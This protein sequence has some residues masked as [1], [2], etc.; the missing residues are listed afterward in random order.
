[1]VA[2]SGSWEPRAHTSNLKQRAKRADS[3]WCWF[4][5][6]QGLPLVTSF[7]RKATPAKTPQT[8]LTWITKY[9]NAREYGGHEWVKPSQHV[10]MYV[11]LHAHTHSRD[12][13]RA[14]AGVI[15]ILA[16]NKNLILN[17]FLPLRINS[18]ASGPHYTGLWQ[19]LEYTLYK[20]T[21]W[22][23]LY[24]PNPA[25]RAQLTSELPRWSDFYSH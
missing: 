5:N 11:C 17:P 10:Y 3:K 19:W 7:P 4:L 23:L 20:G 12:K 8:T 13:G 1:M 25:Y 2:E 9:S 22:Q 24:C 6:S 16:S 21:G 18:W 15:I 14:F